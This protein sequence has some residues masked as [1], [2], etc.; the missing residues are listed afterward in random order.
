MSYPCLVAAKKNKTIF[1][2]PEFAA[3]GMKA[4]RVF[5][6]NRREELIPMPAQSRLFLLPDRFPIAFN[7]EN[8]QYR[9][10]EDVYPVAAFLPPGYTG[11]FNP[12]YREKTKARILPLFSYTA[13]AFYKSRFYVPAVR[14][15]RRKIH[16]L[17]LVNWQDLGNKIRYFKNTKNRLIRH[18]ADCALKSCCANAVN[19][20]LSRFECP[21]P[22]SRFCNAGCIGCISNQPQNS[23]PAT[24]ERL[25]FSPTARELSEI[26][27]MH[28]SKVN[29]AVVSFGQGCEGE[30]LL[31]TETIVETIKSIRKQTSRGTIHINTNASLPE[32]VRALCK[33]GLD[34]MRVSLNSARGEYY[35]RYYNP[36]GY[37]FNDV[38]KSISIAKESGKFVSLN[39]L[40]M[41]GFT[42]E[43][44]E[45]QAMAGFIRDSRVDMI[46]WR[47][48]NFDPQRFF[49][50][51]KIIG[52]GDLLGVGKV[53]EQIRIKFPGL[54]QGYFNLPKEDFY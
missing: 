20:F 52:S 33:A 34:S 41:P 3:C 15:D 39:Y 19:F 11:L 26:A 40:V 8:A 1:D 50:K 5:P 54:K 53:I 32:N 28:I 43:K 14:V 30:P 45:Y 24:Q 6:L 51:M 22:A 49:R 46:Q 37:S 10:L 36:C 9:A 38:R 27:L 42:D 23:C 4:G 48:L 2:Y 31:A 47:N 16:D 29:K 44:Q 18:L 12:A 17:S 35:R 25:K 21:L 13:V 7:S